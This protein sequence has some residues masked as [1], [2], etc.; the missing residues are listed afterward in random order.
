MAQTKPPFRNP[1]PQRPD[2]R[3]LRALAQATGPV[4]YY[5]LT[6]DGC[7]KIG[8]T[9]DVATRRYN[10]C[11][12]WDQ[13]LAIT[14]GTMADEHAEHERWARYCILS[15]YYHRAP[16]LLAHINDLRQRMGVEPT[17]ETPCPCTA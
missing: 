12:S 7:I 13:L 4:V 15:E 8:F 5:I 6:D 3:S 10:L 9:R 1:H 11:H 2:P 17:T 16:E 14:P